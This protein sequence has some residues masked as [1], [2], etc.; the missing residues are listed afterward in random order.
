M[1]NLNDIIGYKIHATDGYLGKVID[2]FFDDESWTIRYIV[3]DTDSL[4]KGR[5][6]LL[7]TVALGIPD[8]ETFS[9]PAKINCD[10]VINSPDINTQKPVYRKHEIGLF[11]HYSWPVYWGTEYY[12]SRTFGTNTESVESGKETKQPEGTT[13]EDQHIRSTNIIRDYHIQAINGDIGHVDDYI[14]DPETWKILYIVVKTRN[15]LPGRKVLISPEWIKE[16]KWTENKLI[17]NLTQDS[18]RK[19]PVYEHTRP[20]TKDYIAKLHQHYERSWI[21]Y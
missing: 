9:F 14:Y 12:S 7:S 19:S 2:F 6:V 17:A 10:Q 18:I 1:Y 13:Q 4:T 15:W 11:K 21:H 3:V 8:K 16:V 5:K 20:L